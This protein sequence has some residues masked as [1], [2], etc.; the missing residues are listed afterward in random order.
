MS[1]ALNALAP[2]PAPPLP[3]FDPAG[4]RGLGESAGAGAGGAMGMRPGLG[5]KTSYGMLSGG[6][7]A[8]GGTPGLD[9]YASVGRRGRSGS[10][11]GGMPVFG[12]GGQQAGASGKGKEKET[13][14]QEGKTTGYRE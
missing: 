2:A 1:H 11:V 7:A 8:G 14:K 13:H 9:G 5:R 6:V 4:L 12:Q 10:V 3:A